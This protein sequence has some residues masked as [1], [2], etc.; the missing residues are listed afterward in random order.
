MKIGIITYDKP[1][2]K[3]QE[4]LSGLYEIG[5]K[6]IKLIVSK[7][8]KFKNK[9]SNSF[10]NHR[11]Y[12]FNGTNYKE[13]SK[14]YGI[15]Y[16][17]FNDKKVFKNLDVALVCG[18]T[19]IDSNL[20]KKNFILNCHSGLIPLRRGL[21]SFKWAIL[22]K[23]PIGNTLHYIDKS[24][25]H[26]K[27]V[28]HKITPLFKSDTIELLAKRHYNEEIRMLINFEYHINN[29]N[30]IKLKLKDPNMRMP[31]NLEKN[32][33]KTFKDYKDIFLK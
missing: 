30:I 16:C 19:I 13:L 29:P 15:E 31:S 28:S 21:D 22:E 12:Q 18:S 1:H 9:K 17:N 27:V 3:T 4:V 32:L 11:P 24:V 7:F 14:F 5:Y 8:K 10:F 33:H 6:K 2:K 25:D 20:I 26:G 23:E